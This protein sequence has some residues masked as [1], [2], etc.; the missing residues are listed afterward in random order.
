MTKKM[1][2]ALAGLIVAGSVA[3]VAL[4]LATGEDSAAEAGQD[5]DHSALTADA[6]Q[7]SPV[8]LDDEGAGRIG[9]TFAVVEHRSLPV[10]VRAVGTVV[11]DETRLATVNPKIN[12]WVERLYVDFTGSPVTEG[13]PLLDIYSPQLVT[14]QEELVLAARLV[15]E[16]GPG[17]ATQNAVQLLES[18]RRRLAYWDIPEDQ[19]RRIEEAGEPTKTL[20]L[21]APASGIV[22]EKN[23]VQGDQIM[24][25]MTV[26]RIAD[27]SRVWVEADVFEKDLALVSQGQPAS[28]S[29]EA[30]PGRVFSGAVTYV[31]PTVSMQSRTARIRI[32]LPN[33]RLDLKPGMYADIT[34]DVPASEMTAVVPRS[35]VIDTG[36][37]TIVFVRASSGALVPRAVTVG[38]ASGRLTQILGGLEPGEQ[39][40][41]S[42]AFL[43]DAES[44]LGT[45]TG[46]TEPAGAPSRGSEH[47]GHE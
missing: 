46:A 6:N 9:V 27:L 18:A 33:P 21:R 42:A 31:Y 4:R 13:E 11:Y 25:G 15:A 28:V 40:V 38:R 22:V 36:E 37:R 7:R 30:F 16:A 43:V 44:N 1:E 39:V 5:H 2:L 45:M 41:S 20:T 32:E 24:P 12:G 17:R 35:S 14:A 26:Y 10:S 23:V 19:I 34:L 3:V 47:A 29:F 8:V